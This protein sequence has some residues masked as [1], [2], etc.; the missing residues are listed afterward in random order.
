MRLVSIIIRNSILVT[1]THIVCKFSRLHRICITTLIPSVVETVGIIHAFQRGSKHAISSCHLKILRRLAGKHR[2]AVIRIPSPG[3]V[4][5]RAVSTLVILGDKSIT[6]VGI[7]PIL[8]SGLVDTMILADNGT[9]G[10]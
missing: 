4:S 6:V 2:S 9:I 7:R 3:V 10:L 1:M 5:R 8:P